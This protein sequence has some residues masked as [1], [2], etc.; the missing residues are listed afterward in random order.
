MTDDNHHAID[1]DNGPLQPWRERLHEI[2]FEADTPAGHTFDI[3]LFVAI[4]ISIVV[5]ML[6]T[7]ESF[8]RN[9]GSILRILEWVLTALFT[10][11]YALRILCVRKPW[12][13]IFSFYGIIDLLSILPTY[14]DL[15]IRCYNPE[16]VSGRKISSLAVIRG[17]RLLRVFRVLKLA[18]YLNEARALLKAFQ[19]A[20]EKIIVFFL[21]AIVLVLIWGSLMYLIE[22]P[23]Q[24]F[25]SIPRG[26]YWAIV[27]MTTVGYG[28]IAPAT[29][30]GQA[31]AALAML[32]AYSVI[33][34]PSGLL[35]VQLV[36]QRRSSIST[37]FCRSCSREGHDVDAT[38]CK[39]CGAAL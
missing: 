38:Y 30:A 7:V 34:V 20:K 5:V 29:V 35:A 25:T 4:G 2:I 23:Q 12:Q 33:A 31:L 37:Q 39:Y 22:G 10:T 6:E 14:I 15:G 1:P 19:Q 3:G 26:V 9:W 8:N 13:Y 16:I 28:D 24:G 36:S 18:Q 27:T 21:F 11:E 17:L 32:T